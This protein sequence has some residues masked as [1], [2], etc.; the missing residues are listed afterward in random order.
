MNMLNQKKINISDKD[1]YF[2]LGMNKRYRYL[3]RDQNGMLWAFERK[4]TRSIDSWSL[5]WDF[6][7]IKIHSGLFTDIRWEDGIAYSVDM[8][9]DMK[10]DEFNAT[11]W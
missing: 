10:E 9:I 7:K 5:F 3:G 4:P 1:Y 6:E 11:G 8:L 2:L